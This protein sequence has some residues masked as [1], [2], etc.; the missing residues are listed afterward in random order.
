[1]SSIDSP[2]LVV[3]AHPD[4]EVLGFGATAYRLGKIAKTVNFIVLSGKAEKRYLGPGKDYLE[5]QFKKV[6]NLLKVDETMIGNFP[7][8]NFNNV[9]SFKIV[10]FIEKAIIKF[11]PKTIVTHHPSDLNIDH[12]FLSNLCLAAARLPQRR[13]DYN[14]PKIR[15]ILFMEVLSSTDWQYPVNNNYFLPNYFCEI[16]KEDLEIKIKALELYEGVSRP[17]PHPRNA[18][19]I[20]ALAAYRGS[21]CGSQFAESFQCC[22]Q[23]Y[24]NK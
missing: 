24:A 6:S 1:M 10:E 16:D 9:E 4:D 22:Y 23:Y 17:R 15:N 7:N 14:L 2:V 18:E 19:T 21:Q 11:K 13:P 20:K 3:V 8:L 12:Q 5:K